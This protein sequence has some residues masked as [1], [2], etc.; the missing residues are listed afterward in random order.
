MQKI[1]ATPPVMR[2]DSLYIARNNHKYC[3]L[4]AKQYE[5]YMSTDPKFT[6]DPLNLKGQFGTFYIDYLRYYKKKIGKESNSADFEVD[7]DGSIYKY[8]SGIPLIPEVVLDFVKLTTTYTYYIYPG[9]SSI[10]ID[11]IDKILGVFKECG[12]EIKLLFARSNCW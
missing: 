1:D 11:D 10:K 5:Q 8:S 6:F 2:G 12:V 9:D 4:T 3:C 7:S